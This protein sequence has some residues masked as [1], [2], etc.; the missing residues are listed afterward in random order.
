MG[1]SGSY[2]NL[3]TILSVLALVIGIVAVIMAA[4]SV[5]QKETNNFIIGGGD[6]GG[7]EGAQSDGMND[8]DR[9]WVIAIGH[10]AD[11]TEYIDEI[12]GQIKGFDIDMV[13]AVCRIAGKNCRFSADVFNRCWD[14]Q[15][16]ETQR[17]GV[18]LYAGYYDACTGWLHTY[19]RDRTFQFTDPFSTVKATEVGFFVKPGNPG[20]FTYRD[21]RGKKIGFLDG[22]LNDE[23][24]VARQDNIQG[25][26]IPPENVIHYPTHEQLAAGIHNGDVD[27]GFNFAYYKSD[28]VEIIPGF[29]AQCALAGQSMMMREDNT[30]WEWWNP[31]FAKLRASAEYKRICRDLLEQHGHVPG[32][33]PDEHCFDNK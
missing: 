21:I 27:A 22:Y 15:I 2:N 29:R 23:V 11:G 3:P 31:A 10:A 19:V 13:N 26:P 4:V 7:A 12:S 24:C 6:K 17:G 30:L 1:D 28:L 16:G 8:D 25:V 18:G 14:S 9:I 32:P 5:S 33:S 20:N